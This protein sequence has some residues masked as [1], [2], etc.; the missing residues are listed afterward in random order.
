MATHTLTNSTGGAILKIENTPYALVITPSGG[1]TYIG[2][3]YP[4]TSTATAAWRCSRVDSNGTTVWADGDAN[5]D[6]TATDLTA[7]SYS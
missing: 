3:A 2:E 7:H 5:F 6:N 1:F 4:G